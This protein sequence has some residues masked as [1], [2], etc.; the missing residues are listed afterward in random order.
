V[1]GA[2][3]GFGVDVG[4]ALAGIPRVRFSQV[5]TTYA[6]SGTVGTAN[7]VFCLSCHKAHGSKYDSTVVWPHYTS[8]AA[9]QTSACGQ[10]HNSG[11]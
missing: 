10:C 5:G 6:T 1:T 7:K 4:D 3:T 2:G 8:G 9:D 11:G